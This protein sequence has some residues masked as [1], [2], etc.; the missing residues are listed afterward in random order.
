MRLIDVYDEPGAAQVLYDL[1]GERNPV[2]NISHRAMPSWDEHL[3]FIAGRPYQDWYLITV[4]GTYVGAIYLTKPGGKSRAG[5]EIGVAILKAH[6]GKGYARAAIEL[7]MQIHGARR[8][9]ANIAPGNEAS[10]H[11]FE[12]LGFRHIQ[13]TYELRGE[14]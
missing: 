7:L 9:L 1:L 13:N 2:A 10:I 3:A 11:L 12:G 8:Y 4:D 6:R 5:D 14:P